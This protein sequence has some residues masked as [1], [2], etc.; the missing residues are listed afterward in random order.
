MSNWLFIKINYTLTILCTSQRWDGIVKCVES[1]SLST[2]KSIRHR[3]SRTGEVLVL[4]LVRWSSSLY[5]GWS[6][7]Q[8]TL[9]LDSFLKVMFI[10]E[11]LRSGSSCNSLTLLFCTFSHFGYVTLN[12]LS[13][14]STHCPNYKDPCKNLLPTFCG[15][16][17]GGLSCFS[18]QWTS[19][20]G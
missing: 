15:V 1:P 16:L 11:T 3:D 5:T 13:N 19:R 6:Q 2:M 20:W 18:T 4:I 17:T 12:Y 7:T 8:G 9:V 14:G 10:K